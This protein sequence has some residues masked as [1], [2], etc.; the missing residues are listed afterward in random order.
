MRSIGAGSPTCRKRFQ[1]RQE[2]VFNDAEQVLAEPLFWFSD[3][4]HRW[5]CFA[6][7]PPRQLREAL[8]GQSVNVIEPGF[9]FGDGARRE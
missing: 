8:S 4:G 2:P 1:L 6:E 3:G 5:A 9:Q 7:P